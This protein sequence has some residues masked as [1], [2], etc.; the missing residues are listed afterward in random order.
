[1]EI[2]SP[3]IL[4]TLF[5]S[6]PNY[7]I[8]ACFFSFRS[9]MISSSLYRKMRNLIKHSVWTQLTLIHI[10]CGNAGIGK[11]VKCASVACPCLYPTIYCNWALS[12]VQ[13]LVYKCF[14]TE[15]FR[16]A[17][18]LLLLAVIHNYN[19]FEFCKYM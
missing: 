5:L 18:S 7:P 10:C 13:L 1:M 3:D 19:N 6:L 12:L 14:I 17:K 16:K 4:I 15:P 11:F 8:S 9:I 2:G